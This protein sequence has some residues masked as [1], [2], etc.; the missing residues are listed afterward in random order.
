MFTEALVNKESPGLINH[1]IVLSCKIVDSDWLKYGVR[2]TNTN[3]YLTRIVL[4]PN[5]M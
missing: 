3:I 2:N 5:V 1:D 4:K